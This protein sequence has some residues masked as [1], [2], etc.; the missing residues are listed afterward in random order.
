MCHLAPFLCMRTLAQP[1]RT[2]IGLRL[3]TSNAFARLPVQPY[4]L[5]HTSMR[6]QVSLD[7]SPFKFAGSDFSHHIVLARSMAVHTYENSMRWV[8]LGSRGLLW[9]SL[10]GL[11]YQGRSWPVALAAQSSKKGQV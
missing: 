4:L 5:Q 10:G 1:D 9:E 2:Y 3:P 7:D 8:C 6:A 11:P